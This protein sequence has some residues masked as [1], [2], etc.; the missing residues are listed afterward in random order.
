MREAAMRPILPLAA[1][2]AAAFAAGACEKPGTQSAYNNS[3]QSATPAMPA[4][5][6]PAGSPSQT[7]AEP[8]KAPTPESAPTASSTPAVSDT[9]SPSTAPAPSK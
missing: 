4:T 2:V 3:G 9:A 1:L 7:P 8:L 5:Q 6:A